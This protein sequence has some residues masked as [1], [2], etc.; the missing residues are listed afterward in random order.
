VLQRGTNDSHLHETLGELQAENLVRITNLRPDIDR[1]VPQPP[2]SAMA[3]A[4]ASGGTRPAS[5]LVKAPAPAPAL[6]HVG[7][8]KVKLIGLTSEEGQKLNGAEG[9]ILHWSEKRGR[10]ATALPCGSSMMIKKENLE[11]LGHDAPS[12]DE[13]AG[14]ILETAR[15]EEILFRDGA[16]SG[17]SGGYGDVNRM[18]TVSA[19]AEQAHSPL[20]LPPSPQAGTPEQAAAAAMVHAAQ[21]EALR[22]VR[23]AGGG[24]GGGRGAGQAAGAAATGK[25]KAA[26]AKKVSPAWL[27]IYPLF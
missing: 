3:S 9:V 8:A 20:T 14:D 11:V 25:G 1:L 17:T 22:R 2:A 23:G 5:T 18:T 21:L 24:G 6:G 12:A 13:A 16:P 7:G 10:F 26:A 15:T 19:Q 27:L 4:S